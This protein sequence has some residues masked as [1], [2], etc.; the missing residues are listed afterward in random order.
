MSKKVRVLVALVA[1]TLVVS[2]CGSDGGG[3]STPT[4]PTP[5]AT[6]TVT[7]V[8]VVGPGGTP[9]PGQTAQF[10]ATAALSNGTT[11]A[12]TSQATWQSSNTGIATVT[13]SGLVTAV[14]AGQAEIRA[15]YQNMTGTAGVSV[16]SPPPPAQALTGVV[17]EE[18]T[19]TVVG[20]A[21]IVV[22]D[23]AFSATS[24]S[25]GR[26]SITGVAS[27]NH[28]LRA[29]ASGFDL[30]ERTVTVVGGSATADISM[31]RTSTGGGG[32]GG[33]GGGSGSGSTCA[34]S[35]IPANATCIGNGTPPV[36]AVCSDGAYSCSQNRSGTCSTHGGV[37]CWV[38]PG[39]L[40]NGLT[41]PD[42]AAWLS[43]SVAPG[44]R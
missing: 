26:Y 6:P 10:T 9:T 8:T 14:A 43:M 15:T 22:K 38:C 24:D 28:T 33:G 1:C 30:A 23:T 13:S 5:P 12:V 42:P 44:R 25:S 37:K 29:T 17:R 20:G 35:S 7:G 2:S 39:V 3:S 19:T 31:K 34:A 21:T 16:A 40:C 27:G 11:Q 41:A 18:G 32:S 4:T 36:T